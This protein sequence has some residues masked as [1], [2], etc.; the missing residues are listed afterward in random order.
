[1]KYQRET[2][3]TLVMLTLAGEQKAYEALVIRYQKAVVSSAISITRNLFM[4]EDAAQDAFVTA[5]MKLNTLQDPQKYASWVCRIAK[6]CAINM[7]TRYRSYLPLDVV[8]NINICNVDALNPA[9]MYALSEDRDEVKRSVDSLPEKVQK[10]IYLHYFEGLSI[11]EIADKM[12]ISAGTVKSQ[13]HNG[14]RRI[15]KELCAMDEKYSD[16]LVERVMKKVE[17]LKLWQVKNDKTG[18]EKVYKKVLR[19]VEELPECVKKHHALADVLMRGWWWLPGEKN[20]ALFKRIADA[21][22]DGKNE[23]VMSFICAREDSQLHGPALID[24]IREKQIPRLMKNGFVKALGR[25]WFWLGY[26][27]FREKKPV[28]GHAAYDKA[29]EILPKD[30]PQRLLIPHL[31]KFEETLSNKYDKISPKLYQLRV[32]ACELQYIDEKLHY[33]NDRGYGEGYMDSFDERIRYIFFYSSACD[34]RFFA[35]IKLGETY[36]GSGGNTQTFASDSETVV[37]PAGKFENCQLWI[38]KYTSN[39]LKSTFKTYYKEGVGIVK[40]IHTNAGITSDPLVLK[41][42][43]VKGDGLLPLSEGNTWNYAFENYSDIIENELKFTV[44]FSDDKKAIIVC[45]HD[46]MRL[47]YDEN[48]WLEMMQKMR[49]EYYYEKRGAHI[50][51]DVIPAV[52]RAEELAKTPLEKAHTKAAASVV[53]RILETDKAFNNESGRDTPVTG[54]VNVFTRCVPHKINNKTVLVDTFDWN[55]Q[56]F[57]FGRGAMSDAMEPLKYNNILETL[58]DVTN[59]IWS[60][61]WVVGASSIV[62]YMRWKGKSTI[63]CEDAGNITTKAGSFENC[64]KVRI[65]N[66]ND[67]WRIGGNKAYYFA[68]GVGI[69]RAEFTYSDGNKTAVYDLTSYTGT[70]DGYMPM[71]DGFMRKYDAIGLTDGFVAGV[72]YTFARDDEG[73]IIIFTDATGV[74]ELP[75]PITNY[76]AIDGEMLEDKLWDIGDWKESHERHCINNFKLLCHFLGRFARTTAHPEKHVPFSKHCLRIM[77]SINEDG[78]IPDAWLCN[79]AYT[80]FRTGNAMFDNNQIDEGYEYLERAFEAFEKWDAIPE[81]TELDVGDKYLYGDIKVIKGK[82]LIKR[83][84][85]SV[86]SIAYPNLFTIKGSQLYYFM[87]NP[88]WAWFNPVRDQKRFKDM[89]ERSKKFPKKSDLDFVRLNMKPKISKMIKIWRQKNDLT[90]KEFGVKLG[91]TGQTISKWE[92]EECYPDITLLPHI[93]ELLECTVNDFFDK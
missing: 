52:I 1:M 88:G 49:S 87:T 39:Y 46:I 92:R 34:G 73:D 66:D 83:P 11:A 40:C 55:L 81:G 8:D 62:E 85:G 75:P 60:D 37:T 86:E 6:N 15:R 32:F 36:V 82:A 23:E 28:E 76:A 21:A 43:D 17:E 70:G 58:Q 56:W 50:L 51:K 4:A 78:T 47:D 2:D 3:E 42:Y 71:E 89:I 80:L 14:R 57:G 31:R 25:E 54:H 59:S 26:N 48:S 7:L 77:E 18:F 13:L 20:D 84:D 74:R 16:T 64:L 38:T 79:Y 45:N 53:R 19:E 33:W 24:F 29:E 61:E 91:V 30:D 41:N 44:S 10:I 72:M 9:D 65:E 67:S 22:L 69:V 68:E 35:D 90:Q 5:W 93:A 63:F 27:L 12:R